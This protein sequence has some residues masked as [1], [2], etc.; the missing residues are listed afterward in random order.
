MADANGSRE[1]ALGWLMLTAKHSPTRGRCIV[2]NMPGC[3]K[4][5]F[6]VVMCF[7]A[8]SKI[9]KSH[10]LYKKLNFKSL[11][12]CKRLISYDNHA[13]ALPHG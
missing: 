1:D 2:G 9:E 7:G 12:A 11:T 8:G 10:R 13:H 5:S 6:L 4:W 3:S